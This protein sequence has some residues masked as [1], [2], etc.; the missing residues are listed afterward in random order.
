MT[1][2][3]ETDFESLHLVWCLMFDQQPPCGSASMRFSALAHE[4]ALVVQF[5]PT[6]P[7][8]MEVQ[9]HHPRVSVLDQIPKKKQRLAMF[10][11]LEEE[12]HGET[13][14]DRIS[15]RPIS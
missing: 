12:K 3:T 8:L 15:L 1:I 7:G 13:M 6:V 11:N 5:N 14:L 2:D 9:K 4:A 10:P